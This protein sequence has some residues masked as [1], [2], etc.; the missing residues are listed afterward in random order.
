MILIC[1]VLVCGL[2]IADTKP[3]PA[4]KQDAAKT[5]VGQEKKG[6]EP[7]NEFVKQHAAAAV[8]QPYVRPVISPEPSH[9]EG[10]SLSAAARKSVTIPQPGSFIN[11]RCL[12]G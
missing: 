2:V 6:K 5:K 10:S 12:P 4:K 9:A 3:L 8:N 7:L 11:Q 1:L